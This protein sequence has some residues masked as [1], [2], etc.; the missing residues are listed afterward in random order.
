M[1][2]TEEHILDMPLASFLG[3]KKSEAEG[4]LLTLTYEDTFRN[5]LDTFHGSII[6]S[7]AEIS[8]GYF[9]A[10][11]FRREQLTTIPVLRR[12]QVKY[13]M[14]SQGQMHSS[15]TFPHANAPEILDELYETGKVLIVMRT[16]IHDEKEQL[17]FKGQF[18]WFVSMKEEYL[19]IPKT[20]SRM[21]N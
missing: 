7:L 3:I 20:V 14:P 18:E 10:Q 6:Y 4:K 11:N 16:L 1:R 13:A 19:K 9:L 8:A 21:E 5:H 12:S 17:L 2:P 15:V